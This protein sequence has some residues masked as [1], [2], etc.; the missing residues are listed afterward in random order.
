MGC[1][2]QPMSIDSD[3]SNSFNQTNSPFN[4]TSSLTNNEAAVNGSTQNQPYLVDLLQSNNLTKLPKNKSLQKAIKS[5]DSKKI[6]G[7]S[8][9]DVNKRPFPNMTSFASSK[10]NKKSNKKLS[11]PVGWKRTI[12]LDLDKSFVA[13]ISPSGAKFSNIHE[14]RD[15]LLTPNTCKCGLECPLNINEVFNFDPTIQIDLMDSNLS[16]SDLSNKQTK[17]KSC[18]IHSEKIFKANMKPKQSQLSNLNK[19]IELN[20]SSSNENFA[21]CF[22]KN[23]SARKPNMLVDFAGLN[24][25]DSLSDLKPRPNS[26]ELIDSLNR[27]ETLNRNFNE[28]SLSFIETNNKKE[29]FEVGMFTGLN[30]S[31]ELQFMQQQ[32]TKIVSQSDRA[33]EHLKASGSIGQDFFNSLADNESNEN[34]W[35]N[36]NN[37]M[38]DMSTSLADVSLSKSSL[39]FFDIDDKR[40]ILDIVETF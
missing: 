18:C 14:I 20:S 1:N 6:K 26:N 24:M 3:L 29:M 4:M 35:A 13:Y 2:K 16:L 40:K 21:E 30:L 31:E 33:G 28:Q 10:Q 7:K 22:K 15:Y 36:T 8:R 19:S 32:E 25:P 23:K 39:S 37:D 38:I 27:I 11:I 9:K 5:T 12:K 34:L 17:S